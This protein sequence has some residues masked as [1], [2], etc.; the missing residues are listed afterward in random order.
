MDS[1]IVDSLEII[2]KFFDAKMTDQL[3]L[4]CILFLN[5]SSDSSVNSNDTLLVICFHHAIKLCIVINLKNHESE[6]ILLLRLQ[7]CDEKA[8]KLIKL[9][10]DLKTKV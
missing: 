6:I 10:N 2:S 9:Y 5:S 3:L 8:N 4:M 1:K 7:M